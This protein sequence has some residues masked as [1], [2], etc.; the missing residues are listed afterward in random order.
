VRRSKLGIQKRNQ[1]VDLGS[2]LRIAIERVHRRKRK[3]Y[4]SMV[5]GVTQRIQHSAIRRQYMDK[6]GPAVG[7]FRLGQKMI[8]SLQRDFAATGVPAHLRGLGEAINLARL[9]ESPPGRET[10]GTALLIEPIDEAARRL[11]PT[12]LRPQ[13]QSMVDHAAFQSRDDIIGIE[14]VCRNVGLFFNHCVPQSI[15]NNDLRRLIIT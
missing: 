8:K 11:I 1:R 14:P 5:E 6:A 9:H 2:D 3:Q 15:S 4:E 10:I 13:G 12:F 7:G